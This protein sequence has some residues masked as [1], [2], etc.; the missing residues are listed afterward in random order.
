MNSVIDKLPL[1]AP[2]SVGGCGSI[3]AVTEFL[4]PGMISKNVCFVLGGW[5]EKNK[6]KKNGELFWSV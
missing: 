5:V 2:V 4:V 3:H 6:G 1:C